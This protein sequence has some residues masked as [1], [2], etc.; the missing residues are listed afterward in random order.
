MHSLCLSAR[1]QSCSNRCFIQKYLFGFIVLAEIGTNIE[2]FSS[3]KR[4]YS[5]A[6][7]ASSNNESAG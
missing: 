2:T 1:N 5:W 3:A 7:L 4:F 6:S